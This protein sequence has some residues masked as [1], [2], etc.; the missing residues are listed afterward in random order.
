MDRKEDIINSR[1][2]TYIA[3]LIHDLKTPVLAQISA[4]DLMLNGAF[5]KLNAQQVEM[6]LQ[7]KESC[8]YS[9]NLIHSILDIYLYK[10]G[11]VHLEIEKFKWDSFIKTVISETEPLAKNREQII[12]NKNN[13]R[14][15]EVFADKFQIKRAIINLI[16]NAV[17]YGFN[18]STIELET[19]M[20]NNNLI[21]NVKNV[22]SCIKRSNLSTLYNKFQTEE[23][24]KSVDSSG[25]G[26]YLV[27]QIINAHKGK[28]FVKTDNSG[29][30]VF[31]FSIPQKSLKS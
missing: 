24:S 9:H 11:K 30:Y 31:G 28:V 15:D 10:N 12:I 2:S 26:L 8:E 1:Q 21:F 5:G 17:K 18:S 3:T 19:K 20:E 7:I 13:I 16:S 27:K 23:R 4:L 29:K 25:L 14:Y 6:I 22:A